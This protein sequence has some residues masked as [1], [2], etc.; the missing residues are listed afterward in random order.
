MLLDMTVDDDPGEDALGTTPYDEYT[1]EVAGELFV[2]ALQ[3]AL[4]Q[5]S[6]CS[7]SEDCGRP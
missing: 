4:N 3:G 6:S 1:L 5:I 2:E 7:K